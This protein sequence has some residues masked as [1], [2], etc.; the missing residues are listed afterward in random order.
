MKSSNSQAEN[1]LYFI[2]TWILNRSNGGDIFKVAYFF[3][4]V[5]D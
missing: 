4:H 3:N 1:N 5:Q 2:G